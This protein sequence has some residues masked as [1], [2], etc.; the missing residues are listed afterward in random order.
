MLDKML[1]TNG[2]ELSYNKRK[3]YVQSISDFIKQNS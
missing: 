2:C 3:Y 1:K